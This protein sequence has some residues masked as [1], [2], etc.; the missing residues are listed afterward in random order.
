MGFLNL[1]GRR[2]SAA[3]VG[4]RGN[5]TPGNR[6]GNVVARATRT[7]WQERGWKRRGDTL[8]GYY[9]TRFG[10]FEGRIEKAFSRAPKFFMRSPPR[11]ILKSRHGA[12][13]H[14]RA[15]GWYWVPFY[16]RARDL[17]TGI[18]R[19]EHLIQEVM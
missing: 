1:W 6:S 16:P 3:D 4:T 7:L 2:A 5:V 15:G 12:C 14:E 10:S 8:K 11:Q 18:L 9:R 17:T 19:I 13:F